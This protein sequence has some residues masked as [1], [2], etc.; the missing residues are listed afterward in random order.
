M[1][2]DICSNP[3]IVWLSLF[4][5]IHL[6]TMDP[7]TRM[8]NK[9]SMGRRSSVDP[10]RIQMDESS[11]LNTA[12]KRNKSGI[13]KFVN[14]TT[15]KRRSSSCDRQ[16]WRPAKNQGAN[17]LAGLLFTPQHAVTPRVSLSARAAKDCISQLSCKGK[18]GRKDQR[19]IS[20]KSVQL[21]LCRH[22][23]SYLNNVGLDADIFTG[24]KAPA[25]PIDPLNMKN[26]DK[27]AFINLF[28]FLFKEIGG[29]GRI[30]VNSSNYT[31]KILF[32][33]K[34]LSYPGIINKSHLQ[35]PNYPQ[36]WPYIIAFLAWMV[37]LALAEKFYEN[38]INDDSNVLSI[39]LNFHLAS[40]SAFNRKEI[41]GP[42]PQEDIDNLQK[43]FCEMHGVPEELMQRL[44]NSRDKIK[45]QLEAELANEK[46]LEDGQHNKKQQIRQL[47][48]EIEEF[49]ERIKTVRMKTESLSKER[50]DV[51]R[52]KEVLL[53]K[54]CELR[55]EKS[56]LAMACSQQKMSKT[57]W[58]TLA[59]KKRELVED[60]RMISEVSSN[61]KKTLDETDLKITS[62]K[63]KLNKQW[64][65]FVNKTIP[66]QPYN[67]TIQHLLDQIESFNPLN[68]DAIQCFKDIEDALQHGL[69]EII[70]NVSHLNNQ[71]RCLQD[72]QH[73]WSLKRKELQKEAELLEKNFEERKNKL[74]IMKEDFIMKMDEL[75]RIKVEIEAETKM[76][77]EQPMR[78]NKEVLEELKA[79][80]IKKTEDLVKFKKESEDYFKMM[81]EEA[82][83]FYNTN[84]EKIES[85][86]KE[87]QV[88]LESKC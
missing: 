3:V 47:S 78:D 36:S 21:A 12:D 15:R 49:T 82:T 5:F 48:K 9:F 26:I 64:M 11:F 53:A 85:F 23:C 1:I 44:R 86:K 22:V 88:L 55:E 87:V 27:N 45:S 63:N 79:M 67:V 17:N 2:D 57:E 83:A 4:I 25:G 24:G 28:N 70:A 39:F 38:V 34:K 58:D 65:E 19:N 71:A 76:I 68:S 32:T 81:M 73:E 75:N 56:K 16:A 10:V 66:I 61:I 20:D 40:Y 13:P 33:A 52:G 72:E 41:A 31:E 84:H 8:R 60:I 14:S 43:L 30:E 80:K 50:E 51:S 18:P 7:L 54:L 37:D 29:K 69:T 42:P 74:V 62:K 6:I 35:T 59:S 46:E 77:N